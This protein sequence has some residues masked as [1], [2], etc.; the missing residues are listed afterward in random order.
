[1]VTGNIKINMNGTALNKVLI[2]DDDSKNVFAL[3]VTLR[4]KGYNVV[5]ASSARQALQLLNGDDAISIILSDIMMP[6]IDGFDLI[7][8]IRDQQQFKDIPVIAVT[9]QAMAEDRERCI[10]AGAS[11][12]ISKPVDVDILLSLLHKYKIAGSENNGK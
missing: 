2:I 7:K 6:D 3:S 10:Q 9:A 11:A 8:M 5:T 12:Y 1:M 4:V